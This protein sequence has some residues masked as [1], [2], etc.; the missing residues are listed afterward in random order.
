MNLLD[1]T[2]LSYLWGKLKAM[3][4]SSL[5]VSGRTVTLKSK[6]GA[7]L[8]T[9]TT[10]DTVYT[11]PANAGNKHIPTGGSTGQ[12]LK[13]SANGTAVWGSAAVSSDAQSI[14]G[15]PVL[16]PNSE[17]NA[18]TNVMFDGTNFY[19]KPSYNLYPEAKNDFVYL[20][21]QTG[22]SMTYDDT[23]MTF[24]L[25]STTNATTMLW[26]T[27]SGLSISSLSRLGYKTMKITVRVSGRTSSVSTGYLYMA[28]SKSISSPVL[29]IGGAADADGG[30]SIERTAEV[31]TSNYTGNDYYFI[32]GINGNTHGTGSITAS[33]V[34][35]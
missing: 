3:F 16:E 11:H 20:S 12:I 14:K 25:T 9:I 13:W 4:A 17:I 1:K 18:P 23:N 31:S 8:S 2:G 22:G 27:N 19:V 30:V 21:G 5:T 33:I 32:L 29:T 10:Q 34:F 6:S 28:A 15:Y 26:T 24:K 35:S 7:T